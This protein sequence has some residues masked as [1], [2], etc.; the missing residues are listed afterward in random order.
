MDF[1]P[2]SE[3][4]SKG[5][6]FKKLFLSVRLLDGFTPLILMIGT[7]ILIHHRV[8]I[9]LINHTFNLFDDVDYLGFVMVVDG[10]QTI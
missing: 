3:T 9:I 10:D 7:I 8:S 5:L 4:Y 1:T 6:F 2:L